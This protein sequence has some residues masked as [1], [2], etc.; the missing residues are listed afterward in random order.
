MV[1]G[2]EASGAD[3]WSTCSRN[4]KFNPTQS[5]EPTVSSIFGNSRIASLHMSCNR[6]PNLN[7]R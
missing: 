3:T 4:M 5:R 7:I 2:A 1:S 6:F